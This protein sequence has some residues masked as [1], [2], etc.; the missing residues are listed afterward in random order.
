MLISPETFEM[1]QKGGVVLLLLIAVCWLVWDRN[2]LLG[3]L[4]SKDELIA[5]KDSQL[6]DVTKQTI[7]VMTELKGLLGGRGA[8][9]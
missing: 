2:R 8:R 5:K 6:L 7:M 3:S 9:T 4:K 1:I